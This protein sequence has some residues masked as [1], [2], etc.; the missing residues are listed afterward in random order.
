MQYKN[1]TIHL[2]DTPGHIDFSSEMERSIRILDCCIIVISASSGIQAHTE[3]LWKLLR[4]NNIPTIFF[5]NK[6]DITGADFDRIC[7]SIATFFTNDT[8]I[9]AKPSY[10][11]YDFYSIVNLFDDNSFAPEVIDKI[12]EYDDHILERYLNDEAIEYNSL[13]SLISKL[14][15]S[16]DI[17]PVLCGSCLKNIGITT[18]LDIIDKIICTNYKLEDSFSGYVYKIRYDEN[19]QKLTYIKAL[20]GTINVKDMLLHN[21][22]E[23]PVEEKTNQIR[24][25]NGNS[26]TTTTYLNAGE[27]GALLG[28]NSSYIG[29]SF[30][31]ENTYEPLL[32]PALKSKVMFDNKYNNK[33]ILKIFEILT[34]EDPTLS[35]Y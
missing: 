29:E 20:S 28:L 32:S 2:V 13:L 11:N 5:I 19:L 8:L 6:L 16:C 7:E 18:L 30:G 10:N 17:F 4:K 25:Y 31:D 3:T 26:F 14:T 23:E 22:L 24:I 12:V 1:S 15:M 21:H 33:E 34:E 9:M 27:Y 35:V